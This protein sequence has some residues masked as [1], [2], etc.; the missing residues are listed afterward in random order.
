VSGSIGRLSPGA[1]HQRLLPTLGL[2]VLML[3]MLSAGVGALWPREH[4]AG[5]QKV[6][7]RYLTQS[8]SLTGTRRQA[9]TNANEEAVD[10][11]VETCAAAGVQRLARRYGIAADFGP[12]AARY[13]RDFESATRAARRAGC[14]IGLKKG[15]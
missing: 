13:A 10:H 2:G 8:G 11:S 3:A 1:G 14:L 15:G 5:V 7:P 6:D 9:I 12:V 4:N